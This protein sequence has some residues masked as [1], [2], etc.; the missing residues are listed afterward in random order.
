VGF[1]L[2]DAGTYM[3]YGAFSIF[4]AW[5]IKFLILRIGGAT[6]Y[7]RYQPFFL[8]ILTGYTAGVTL[9]IVVDMLWFPGAGHSIHGY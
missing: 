8:G 9:S 4:L 5:G 6:L 1:A 2:S 7:R 3:R